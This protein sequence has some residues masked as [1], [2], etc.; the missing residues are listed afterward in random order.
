MTSPENHAP[1]IDYQPPIFGGVD[2]GGTNIKIGIVDDTGRPLAKTNI[3]TQGKKHPDGAIERI[4]IAIESLLSQLRQ[5]RENILPIGLGVPGPIDTAAGLVLNPG[6]LPGW[7]QFPIRERLQNAIGLRV[8][9]AN[10]ANAAAFGEYWV[11]SGAQYPSIVMFTMGTGIGSGIIVDG[12]IMEGVN[13]RGS[14]CGHMIIDYGDDAALCS[15]GQRGHVEAYASAYGVIRRVK[16]EVANGISSSIQH[17]IAAGEQLTPLMVYEEA[18]N[19]DSLCNHNITQ[20]ARYL[21]IGIVNVIHTIDPSA[22]ILGGAMNF[23][24]YN[25]DVGQRFLDTVRDEVRQ[26]MDPDIVA[27]TPI[28]FASLG[29]DAGFIGAAGLARKSFA[30]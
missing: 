23:G 4:Q 28:Q 16:E 12:R 7:R 14:E 9:M 26:R 3:P 30:S 5:Q 24:G 15:C 27:Q 18:E 25:S 29:T 21:G 10:D 17:R 20:T 6:N 2:V 22:I 13:S 8:V 11:G 19:G 1:A